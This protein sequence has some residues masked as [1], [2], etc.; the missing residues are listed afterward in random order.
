MTIRAI[1]DR[2]SEGGLQTAGAPSVVEIRGG[3]AD[4]GKAPTRRRDPIQL[5]L[6]HCLAQNECS[7]NDS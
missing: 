2:R 7:L 6:M 5:H 1:C 4:E 3:S